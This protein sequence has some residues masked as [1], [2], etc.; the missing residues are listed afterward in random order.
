MKVKLIKIL[1]PAVGGQ[2]GGLLTEWLL[3]AFETE[4]YDVQ[5]ISLPG[6]AQRGGST[7][8]YLEA[9]PLTEDEGVIFSQFP[10]PGDVDL[11]LS[12]EFLEL[13]RMLERGYGS[14]NTVIISS[15]HRMYSTEEKLP[16]TSGIYED[17]KLIEFAKE[18]S[19][20]FIGLNALNLAKQNGM[21]E[22]ASNAILFGALSASNALPLSKES[23]LKAIEKTAVSVK[24]NLQAFETGFNNVIES[25]ILDSS[26]NAVPE[27][28]YDEINYLNPSDIEKIN[29]LKSDLFDAYPEYLWPFIEEA[30]FRQADYQG[31]WYA[32]LFVER[33]KKILK[34]E[35][36]NPEE[37][38]KMSEYVIKNLALLMTYED[39]IRVSE[40]KVR[41]KRFERIKKDMQI[42]DDQIF[43]VIDYLKPEADEIYGLMP[44]FIVRPVLFFLS[45]SI[46]RTFQ[47]SGRPVAVAQKPVTTSFFGYL[48]IWTLSKMKFMRPSSYRYK[49]EQKTIDLYLESAEKFGK[50]D[51]KLGFSIA[52]SGSIIKGY[53]R[54]R[55]R[56]RDS[57]NRLILNILEKSYEKEKRNSDSLTETSDIY[58]RSADLV[59]KSEDGI[60]KA[61][62]MFSKNFD[63]N[64]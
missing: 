4:E 11:I 64:S 63:I 51:Y 23:F 24:S 46:F 54:V 29:D 38:F 44:D 34:I 45:S 2:G 36:Q 41:D 55:R 22:L 43:E 48:R 25:H 56:T 14:E 16:I 47:R 6:L 5:S 42:S 26:S 10:V 58:N 7:T 40:L 12:Q 28:T 37:D 31:F 39:G 32:E 60:E 61:E 18:F 53:G 19:K 35:V 3:Q 59:S 1:I 27:P 17:E 52:K 50:L 33:I 30:L 57:F 15:T 8:Y 9:Y 20:K 13:G 21:N 49:N 62:E